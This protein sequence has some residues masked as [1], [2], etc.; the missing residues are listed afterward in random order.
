V[1]NPSVAVTSI[2]AGANTIG[3]VTVTNA[4]LTTTGNVTVTSNVAPQGKSASTNYTNRPAANTE[5]QVV[6]AAPGAG[7]SNVLGAV[8][9]SY[10]DTPTGGGLQISDD[11]GIVFQLDLCCGGSDEIVWNPGLKL[12]TNDPVTVTLLAGGGSVVGAV[13]VHVWSE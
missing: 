8:N 1:T 10:N 11:T 12:A 9:W 2:A 5:A 3:A 13:N 7:I 4:S 6:V